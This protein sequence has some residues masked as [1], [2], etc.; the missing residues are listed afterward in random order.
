MLGAII[1]DIVGSRYE[2]N[3]GPKPEKDEFVFFSNVSYFTDDTVMTCAVASALLNNNKDIV[4][5]YKD[6][7]RCYP[8][9]GYGGHFNF[10]MFSEETK[11]YDSFGNGA[12]MR[13]SP[14]GFIARNE[15]EVKE[16]SR[17]VTAV[18]HDNPEG[19]KGAEVTAMCVFMAYNGFPKSEIKKYALKEYPE[20]DDF[21]YETLKRFYDFD[22]TCQR[23]VPQAIY[24]FLISNSFEDAIRTGI[25]IGGDSD[26]LCAIIGGIAEA[27]YGI[28]PKMK[29]EALEYFDEFD[30]EI[31]L[32]PLNEFAKKCGI[33]NYIDL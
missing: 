9:C 25:S 24:C 14:V 28:P 1:G 27:Y 21:D 8:G 11:P 18:T 22:E 2:F 16:L 26:T 6:I 32:K 33:N 3:R 30:K 20:I 13:V 15:R 10:W 31:L 23:T 12:A 19:I 17:K 4:K 29:K 5:T 7:G